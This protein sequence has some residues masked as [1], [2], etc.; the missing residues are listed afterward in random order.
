MNFH[1]IFQ[2]IFSIYKTFIGKIVCVCYFLVYNSVNKIPQYNKN[3]CMFN[4]KCLENI[5][6][7][8][9]NSI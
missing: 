6:S 7:F 5:S 9:L 8:P 4:V 2:E 3:I 1:K